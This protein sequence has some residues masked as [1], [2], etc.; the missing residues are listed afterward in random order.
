MERLIWTS[1]LFACLLG[2]TACLTLWRKRQRAREI[3]NP[4][5]QLDAVYWLLTPTLTAWLTRAAVGIVLSILGLALAI[6]KLPSGGFGPFAALPAWQTAIA[7]LICADFAYYWTHRLMHNSML[8]RVHAV[9]HS[10]EHVDWHSAL[11]IHPLDR[12]VMGVATASFLLILGFPLKSMAI[13]APVAGL[14]GILI[15]LD[16]NVDLG[17]L[18]FV[19]ATPAFH[20]WHHADDEA[21]YGKNL[22]GIF[23][24]WD[25]LFGTFYMPR[26]SPDRFG[27]GEAVPGTLLGQLLYP[28]R[29]RRRA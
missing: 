24:V 14:V 17:P 28:F 6:G 2:L 8:W 25:L 22:A 26:R 13:A 15:H 27:A 19:V 12:V 23:P 3:F 4:D 29:H 18:R 16:C 1:I 21:A 20:R 10:S 5:F 9:H 7:A 11:R